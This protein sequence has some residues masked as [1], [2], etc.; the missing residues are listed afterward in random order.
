LPALFEVAQNQ[1][2]TQWAD[3]P[4]QR[5]LMAV[6]QWR[7]PAVYTSGESDEVFKS[8]GALLAACTPQG[9]ARRRSELRKACLRPWRLSDL[10]QALRSMSRRLLPGTLPASRIN[11]PRFPFAMPTCRYWSAA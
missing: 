9:P 6:G 3:K 1:Q 4:R 7:P 8:N 10:S 11:L 2:W 5:S